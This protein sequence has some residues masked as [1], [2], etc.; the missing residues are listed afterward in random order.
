MKTLYTLTALLLFI[1][2]PKC[3]AGSD[4]TKNHVITPD[5]SEC[6]ATKQVTVCGI[7]YGYY[8]S[9]KIIGKPTF[10]DMGAPYPHSTF[11]V[12]VGDADVLKFNYPLE[13]LVNKDVCFTGVIT[14]YNDKPEMMVADPA[15]ITPHQTSN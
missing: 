6:Y 13:Y 14:V 11:T 2:P 3:F 1:L 9:N 8:Y 10:L 4:K 12:I 5:S 7:V 15:Q